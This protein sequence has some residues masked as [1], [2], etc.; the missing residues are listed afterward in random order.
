MMKYLSHSALLLFLLYAFYISD[1]NCFKTLSYT[2]G[3]SLYRSSLSGFPIMNKYL[4][5]QDFL[6]PRMHHLQLNDASIGSNETIPVYS[7]LVD[8]VLRRYY[9]ATW[10]SWW[11]QIILSVISGV[12]LLFARQQSR[13]LS[14]WASGY[15]FNVISVFIAYANVLWTWNCALLCNRLQRGKSSETLTFQNLRQYARVAIIISLVGMIFN[16]ISAEQIV[17]NLASKIL[18]AQPAIFSTG[19][20]AAVNAN[21]V[22]QPL[23][24]FLVQAN[25]NT[26]VSHFAPLVCYLWQL[27]F[28]ITRK[29]TVQ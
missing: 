3:N 24:I 15:A 8:K 7:G 22:F 9:R 11:V 29:D 10:L 23:D 19:G 20:M 5:P 2:A 25:T 17:G 1:V 4:I 18:S 14:I 27:Q 12:T 21:N 26:L 28:S 6:S 13:G 16:I